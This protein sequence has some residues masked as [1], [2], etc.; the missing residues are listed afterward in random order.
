MGWVP[1][2]L[3]DPLVE[4]RGVGY[5]TEHAP[6]DN[7]SRRR[8]SQELHCREAQHAD[9]R[10]RVREWALL[11]RLECH[12]E[13]SGEDESDGCGIHTGKCPFVELFRAK[14]SPEGQDAEDQHDAW[15]KEAYPAHD[16]SEEGL[17][18]RVVRDDGAQIGGEIEEWTWHGLRGR[19]AS[20]ELVFS[21]PRVAICARLFRHLVEQQ[22]QKDL[23]AAE[24]ER[25]RGVEHLEPL[26]G[27]PEAGARDSRHKQ[28]HEEE[29]DP[30]A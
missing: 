22:R 1:S 7:S 27:L 3:P 23:P 6:G 9:A 14:P 28:Q 15:R 8:H 12:A 16:R 25:S 20:E 18:A 26:H 10:G 19:Q 24:D 11:P 13:D 30:R 4:S 2:E 21:D 5:E 29:T 17:K